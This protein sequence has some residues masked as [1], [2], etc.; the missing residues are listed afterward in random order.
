VSQVMDISPEEVQ[1]VPSFGTR[2][3]IDYLQGMAQLGKKFVLLLD[4]D[5]VLS[6]DE[7][8]DLNEAAIA[9]AAEVDVPLP[10]LAE[11]APEPERDNSAQAG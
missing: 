10:D 2:V 9:G 7:A 1:E 6:A 8:L 3:R 11:V 4:I 5:K